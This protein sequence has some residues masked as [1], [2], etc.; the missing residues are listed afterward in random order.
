MLQQQRAGTPSPRMAGGWKRQFYAK[1]SAA[2]RSTFCGADITSTSCALLTTLPALT[3]LLPVLLVM[4][5]LLPVLPVLPLLPLLL[6]EQPFYRPGN[7]FVCGFIR[8]HTRTFVLC[9]ILQ[10]YTQ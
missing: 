1:G 9:L 4:L 5:L 8:A 10:I 7:S 3:S 6:L 2:S